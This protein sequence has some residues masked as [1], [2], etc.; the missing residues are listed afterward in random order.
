MARAAVKA[1]Q[2]EKKAAVAPQRGRARGARRRHA[3]GGNPNQQLFFVRMRR[4]A[5]PVYVILAV[6]FAATFAFLGVGSGTNGGLDQ[7]F[8]GL[9][10]FHHSGTSVSSAQRYIAKHPNDP[11]GYRELA[12]AYEGKSD[13]ADAITALEQYTNLRRKD[14]SA[15]TE[16][17][18][19]Q[20]NQAQSYQTAAANAYQAGQLAAPS[21]SFLPTGKLG[22]ALG[23]NQ[24]EQAASSQ[25]NAQ[26]QTLQQQTQGAYQSAIS[27]YQRAA[28]LQPRNSSAWL[29]L[30][31][32]AQQAAQ[33]TGD[34]STAIS[35]Y[36]HY[37]KLNPDSTTAAQ[38]KQLIKQLSPAPAP[39][40]KKKK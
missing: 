21:Q 32:A 15:W 18:G 7:L 2:Q 23:S 19:L 31:Q 33:I 3:G 4:S 14:V 12:T 22:T 39:A 16:L 10:F 20:L 28:S 36:K 26:V 40:P 25:A 9:N 29:Q 27:S 5:K 13:T 17:A 37:V 38:L 30:G 24:I 1:R 8:N 34:T 11:K 35:A 6:L